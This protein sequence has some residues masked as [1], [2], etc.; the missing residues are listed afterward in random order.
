MTMSNP[1]N[2]LWFGAWAMTG[3]GFCLSLVAMLSI[4]MFVLPI[5]VAAT[6]LLARN[7]TTRHAWP[8]LVSGASIPFLYMTYLNRSGP[9]DVCTTTATGQGCVQEYSPW[10]FLLVALA[11]TLAGVLLHV[12]RSPRRPVDT[13]SST[14]TSRP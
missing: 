4:G 6:L 13:S 7:H 12:R 2:W 8:G 10:P 5:P 1:R 9:G 3:A 14:L 11:M